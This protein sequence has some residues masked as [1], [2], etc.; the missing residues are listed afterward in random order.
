MVHNILLILSNRPGPQEKGFQLKKI[1]IESFQKYWFI[2]SLT[3][4]M[5]TYNQT[6][7][8]VLEPINRK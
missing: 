3:I 7:F 2:S 6:N 1:C 8:G 4:A 5:I